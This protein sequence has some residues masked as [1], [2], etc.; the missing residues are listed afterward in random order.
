M[1]RAILR[2]TPGSIPVQQNIDSNAR[3]YTC[4]PE[5]PVLVSLRLRPRFRA[6]MRFKPTGKQSCQRN[7][8]K[9]PS[10]ECASARRCHQLKTAPLLALVSSRAESTEKST[11]LNGRY[12]LEVLLYKSAYLDIPT[13]WSLR[14]VFSE[15]RRLTCTGIDPGARNEETAV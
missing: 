8:Q 12:G 5:V 10:S 9:K 1:H 3:K 15:P 13:T 4:G 6:L 11:W 2:S 7:M 14:I